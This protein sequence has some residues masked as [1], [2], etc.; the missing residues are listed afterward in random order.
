MAAELPGK[1]A[2]VFA[3]NVERNG[4]KILEAVLVKVSGEIDDSTIKAPKL[5]KT[6]EKEEKCVKNPIVFE[7]TCTPCSAKDQ[8]ETGKQEIPHVRP[9]SG[10][11][12]RGSP[13]GRHRRNG[14]WQ[15]A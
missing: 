12:D 15:E 5:K 10:R 3:P 14:R 13:R 4:G 9:A 1:I 2:Y 6:V 8:P 11:K 7:W